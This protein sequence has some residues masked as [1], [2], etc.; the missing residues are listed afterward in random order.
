MLEIHAGLECGIIGS[1]HPGLDMISIGP[2]LHNPHSPREH[3]SISSIGRMFPLVKDLVA[4]LQ[5]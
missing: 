4:E 1:K 2:D 3:V 5:K